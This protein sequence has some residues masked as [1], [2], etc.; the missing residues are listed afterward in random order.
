MWQPNH[1]FLD[2]ASTLILLQMLGK[3][4]KRPQFGTEHQE[5]IGKIQTNKAQLLCWVAIMS[6]AALS[7][8]LPIESLKLVM[9]VSIKSD[10]AVFNLVSLNKLETENL[11]G[12]E[13]ERWDSFILNNNCGSFSFSYAV[14]LLHLV[15]VLSDTQSTLKR[16]SW[17]YDFLYLQD[18]LNV[19]CSAS[20]SL[21][22]SLPLFLHCRSIWHG[23]HGC[24]H[25]SMRLRAFGILVKNRRLITSWNNLM[26]ALVWAPLSGTAE[27]AWPSAGRFISVSLDKPAGHHSV[28]THILLLDVKKEKKKKKSDEA[29]LPCLRWKRTG[30]LNEHELSLPLPFLALRRCI[31]LGIFCKSPLSS[32][33]ITSCH[34]SLQWS[35]ELSSWGK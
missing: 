16:L 28:G 30:G 21:V 32:A 33:G 13:S 15:T 25:G 2:R 6:L 10:G 19:F 5:E 23:R 24:E 20:I 31:C 35:L 3:K 34:H 1:I 18:K 14:I 9:S 11:T 27:Q 7:A 29:V 12:E 26:S 22:Q 17:F 8:S 4:K